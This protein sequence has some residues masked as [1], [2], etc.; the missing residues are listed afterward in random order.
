MITS[1]GRHSYSGVVRV[2]SCYVL[3]EPSLGMANDSRHSPVFCCS[4]A[5]VLGWQFE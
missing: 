5:D 1:Q 4:K 2:E 3:I